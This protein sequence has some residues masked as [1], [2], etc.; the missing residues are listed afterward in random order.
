MDI[1]GGR[2]ERG[3]EGKSGKRRGEREEISVGGKDGSEG[4]REG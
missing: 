1:L 3:R 2:K 4:G